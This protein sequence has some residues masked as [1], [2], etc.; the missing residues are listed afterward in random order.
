MTAKTAD[1][2]PNRSTARMISRSSAGPFRRPISEQPGLILV[3]ADV[4]GEQ[5]ALVRAH[6]VARSALDSVE[7]PAR[8]QATAG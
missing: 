7:T 8:A 5:M 6:C 3:L 1:L 2:R 4:V